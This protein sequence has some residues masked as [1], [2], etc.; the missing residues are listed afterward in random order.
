MLAIS[1]EELGKHLGL[2][3]ANVNRQ[4]GQLKLANLIRIDGTE[5]SIVDETGLDEIAAPATLEK[6]DRRAGR[7]P[8]KTRGAKPSASRLKSPA[9]EHASARSAGLA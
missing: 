5:I 2:S 1:Q 8:M 9:P 4:L 6:Q 3:R 7:R